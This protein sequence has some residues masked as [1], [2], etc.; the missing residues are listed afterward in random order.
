MLYLRK[1]N[2]AE[3]PIKSNLLKCLQ[4]PAELLWY[5][6]DF[7]EFWSDKD[8][9]LYHFKVNCN[10]KKTLSFN[11]QC[12]ISCKQHHKAI[13]IHMDSMVYFIGDRNHLLYI[14]LFSC[15]M[16]WLAINFHNSKNHTV[17]PYHSHSVSH[18]CPMHRHH[19]GSLPY[20]CD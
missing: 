17:Y 16:L 3:S 7:L 5:L 12:N 1:H 18:S 6:G 4:S 8:K 20:K 19:F 15:A 14:H 10:L 11:Y 13:N 9:C 2:A